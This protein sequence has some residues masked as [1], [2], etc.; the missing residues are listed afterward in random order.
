MDYITDRPIDRAEDD[1][2]GRS[3]FSKQ[4][5]ETIYNYNSKDGL[6]IGLFG[7]WG[8]GKTSIVNMA[9]EEIKEL[10]KNDENKP[11]IMEFSVWNYSDKTNLIHLFL[12]NL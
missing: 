10:A 9:I 1:L 8:T 11:I 4:L 5:G 7:E 2:L 6:V 12:Q 3:F